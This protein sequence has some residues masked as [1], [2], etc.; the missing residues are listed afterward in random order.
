MSLSPRH[1]SHAK[2]QSAAP[3]R[4]HAHNRRIARAMG[5]FVVVV[6]AFAAGFVVRS[7]SAFVASLGFPVEEHVDSAGSTTS[8]KTTYDSVSARVAEVEDL[9]ASNSM[10]EYDMSTAT[11][12]MLEDMMKST[13]DPY[14]MYY[15]PDRYASYIKDSANRSYAGVG[16]LFADYNGRA[17]VVDVFEGSEAEA[18]GV[19][20]GDFVRA[21]DGDGSKNWTM[22]EVVNSLAREDGDKV[23]ITWV[24]PTSKDAETGTEFTTTLTCQNYDVQNV[25]SELVEENVGYIRL[26]QITQ[27]SA[28]L[29]RAAVSDLTSQGASSFVLDIRDN[30]GG[31]LTQAVDIASMF[32]PS[33][34]LVEI[35]TID[36]ATTKTASGT[37]LT[38][39]PLVVLTNGYTSAAAEVL[40]AALQDNMRAQVVGQTTMGKG[41]VQVVRE[42]SFGG[43]IRYTA[44][45][46]HSPLGH[47]I[48]GVGVVP[49]I[50][51]GASEDSG[52]DTQRLVAVD[53]ARSL[54]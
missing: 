22:T 42:L 2:R 30:P 47:D 45:Y 35:E 38:D 28:E 16:V 39:A 13:G 7:Q 46:Y 34:V 6:L 17:Y 41:S 54:A 29:V 43:A 33:G 11:Y 37:T 26:H 12:S 51:V 9:L 8:V 4:E 18:K 49:D 21:V 36:G 19:T 50:S 10:D 20:Q 5:V 32:V 52:S 44:A 40:A 48:D 27:N 31:Y 53:T 1:S 14:A 3:S 23:V 24:H 15:S 25:E